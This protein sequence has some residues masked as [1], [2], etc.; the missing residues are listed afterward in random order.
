MG[1]PR[2]WLLGLALAA[3]VAWLAVGGFNRG[4]ATHLSAPRPC[5]VHSDCAGGR[6]FAVPNED[7]FATFG[8]CAELCLGD[9]QCPAGRV[10][11]ATAKARG[12]LV[13]PHAGLEPGE[14]VCL[15]GGP[16]P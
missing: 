13:P 16:S 6:C 9:L 5:L 3:A 1:D 7:G 11:A 12:Q 2:R 14:R 15:P 4:S 10:C 8:G